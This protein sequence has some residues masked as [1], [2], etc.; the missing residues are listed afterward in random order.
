M[1]VRAFMRPHVQR[2]FRQA[3]ALYIHFDM[4]TIKP[5]YWL[6]NSLDRVREFAPEAR[7]RVGFELWEVQRGNEPD[8]WKPMATIG[9]GVNE[10]RVHAKGEYRVLYVTKFADAVYVLHAF[11]KK[12]QQTP[13]LDIELAT[14]PYR[15]LAH[16]MKRAHS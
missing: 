5:L 9:A 14:A 3:V 1:Y 10:I 4:I 13:R 15:K 16:E 12:T 11:C 6:G 8:D 2:M 7:A